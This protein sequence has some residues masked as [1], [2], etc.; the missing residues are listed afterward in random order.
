[1]NLSGGGSQCLLGCWLPASSLCSLLLLLPGFGLLCCGQHFAG[2]LQQVYVH[3]EQN[4][5]GGQGWGYGV[6]GGFVPCKRQHPCPAL[7]ARSVAVCECPACRL[8]LADSPHHGRPNP[9]ASLDRKVTFKTLL[10]PCTSLCVQ[11]CASTTSHQ[12]GLAVS[13]LCHD[14]TMCPVHAQCPAAGRG[15]QL[16]AV[17]MTAG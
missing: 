14:L 12:Y 16:L 15:S 2:D 9:L 10:L 6:S 13:S 11:I 17:F 4:Y 3:M 8:L 7:T 5:S 1:M